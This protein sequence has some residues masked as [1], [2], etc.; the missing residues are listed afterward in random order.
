MTRVWQKAIKANVKQYL[1]EGTSLIAEVVMILDKR[2]LF[3][4]ITGIL[5]ILILAGCAS[6]G[7]DVKRQNFEMSSLVKNDIDLVTETHQRVV[8]ATLRELA[9]K[10][11]K[12]NPREWKKEGNKSLEDAVA[13]LSTDPF[14]SVG[15]KTSIDCIRLAF[16]EDFH[17]D[18][19]KA[20]V[21][22]LETMVLNSYDGHREL[23]IYNM[24]DAQKLY[25]S[26]RNIELASWLI[27]TKHDCNNTLFLLSSDKG[28]KMN[29]SIERLF[30]KMINAQD[31]M[32]QIMADRSNRTIKNVLQSLVTAF[33]PI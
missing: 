33:I 28:G 22:G 3:S 32:A 8:F 5:S 30:G 17:G 24:L 15:G 6:S 18:R 2:N 11:Y 10:L 26:A 4:V 12:R 13:A 21:A 29:V 1:S 27:R 7:G 25:N 14:P 20:F 9:V 16:D 19:V 23:Y 31:M